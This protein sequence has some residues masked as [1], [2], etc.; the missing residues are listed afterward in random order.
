NVHFM[1]KISALR[2]VQGELKKHVAQIF[3]RSVT[4]VKA[5]FASSEVCTPDTPTRSSCEEYIGCHPLRKYPCKIMIEGTADQAQFL[6]IRYVIINYRKI[7]IKLL[8]KNIMLHAYPFI[9]G[10][11]L[12]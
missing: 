9:I 3:M 7:N 11:S 12:E 10:K 5:I 1:H 4:K 8:I 2:V 6:A